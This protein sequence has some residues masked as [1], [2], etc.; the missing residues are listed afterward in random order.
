M[1]ATRRNHKP[2]NGSQARNIKIMSCAA[3]RH[4]KLKYGRVA[5][6]PATLREAE[7]IMTINGREIIEAA[8]PLSG[9]M[10]A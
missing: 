4:Y 7:P 3:T 9:S 8:A 5:T 2:R 10:P 1:R 6:L